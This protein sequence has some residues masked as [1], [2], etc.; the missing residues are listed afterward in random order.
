MPMDRIFGN[1]K[2]KRA[3]LGS[4][5]AKRLPQALII[6]GD[7]GSGRETFAREICASACC[8]RADKPCGSCRSCDR[9]LRGV[10]P[11]IVIIEREE[12]KAQ[13]GI[14]AIREMNEMA[15][16]GPCELSMLFFII[17]D[18]DRMT[19]QAQNAW[20]LTLENP[21]EDVGFILLC[22]NA[23]GMLETIRSRAPTFRM[24][25]FEPD[26]IVGY[27][28]QNSAKYGVFTD[29]RMMYESA[30]AS[31]GSIG[32]TVELLS[33]GMSSALHEKREA[34]LSLINAVIGRMP[35][36]DKIRQAM[37]MPETRDELSELLRMAGEIIRDL[38][39]LKCDDNAPMTFFT[40]DRRNEAIMLSDSTAMSALLSYREA[41]FEAVD[42]LSANAGIKVVRAELSLRLGLL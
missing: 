1:E 18:A 17:R 21:P 39:L 29:E 30:V 3:L 28:K 6:E 15:L 26:E 4:I 36:A 22:S 31:G 9:I 10:T 16:N 8:E 41:V 27:I 32:R 19:V 40:P 24:Q 37:R 5:R 2:A 7:D 38:V 35:K 25:R 12:G 13:I 34:A 20:L 33:G 14:G 42:S 23:K 11:D